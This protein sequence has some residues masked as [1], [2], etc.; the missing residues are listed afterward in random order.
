MPNS[1]PLIIQGVL[2]LRTSLVEA[3]LNVQNVSPIVPQKRFPP[4]LTGCRVPLL[5]PP[6]KATSFLGPLSLSSS[7]ESGTDFFIFLIGLCIESESDDN[8]ASAGRDSGGVLGRAGCCNVAPCTATD[9][10]AG[11]STGSYARFTCRFVRV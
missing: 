5:V 9:G 1:I 6:P 10:P 2:N 11:S 4:R 3:R 7:L 8:L